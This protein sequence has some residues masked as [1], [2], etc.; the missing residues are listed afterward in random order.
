MEGCGAKGGRA[1][2]FDW[3][4]TAGNI[5]ACSNLWCQKVR[6]ELWEFAGSALTGPRGVSRAVAFFEGVD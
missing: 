1:G 3:R 5:A 6:F 2:R 4:F